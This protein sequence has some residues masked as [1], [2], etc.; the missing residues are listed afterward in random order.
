MATVQVKAEVRQAGKKGHARRL[1]MAGK[2]PAIIYGAG[3]ESTPVTLEA[4]SFEYMLRKISGNQILDLLIAGTNGETKVLIKEVQRNPIDERIL[5]VD[6]QHISMTHKVRVKIPIHLTGTALGVKEGG[7]LEHLEREV[8]VECLASDIPANITLDIS[9]LERG[10]AIHVRDLP[11]P[12]NV[13]IHEAGERLV[14]T[15]VGKMKEEEVVA[16]PAAA[17]ATPAPAAETT[18]GA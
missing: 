11:L 4:R 16:A 12:E 18:K 5:H 15:V 1:R 13:L 8:E 17:E 2:I 10:M 14:V 7:I 3:E 6:L 9:H